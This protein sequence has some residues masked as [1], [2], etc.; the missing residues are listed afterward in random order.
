MPTATP[1]GE[2]R[3]RVT[4]LQELLTANGVGLALIRQPADLYYYTGTVADGFLAVPATGSPTLLARRPRG[5]L[6][7][8]EIPWEL[9]FYNDLGE[10]PNL[11]HDLSLPRDAPIG[12]E[13][14]VLPATLYL[15][16]HHKIFPGVPLRDISPLIRQQR[17][18]KSAFEIER[19]TGAAAI[20]DEAMASVSGLLCPGLTE[21]ELSAALE[22]RLRLLGHQ[23]LIRV[24]NFSLEIFF[25]HVLSGHAGLEAAYTDTP[26]GG[27]GF[28]PAFP[29]GASLKPLG[30]GEPVTV[31]LGS[32]VNGYVADMTR[33]FV[34]GDLPPA[35]WRAYDL[36]LELF[37]YFE[38]RARPGVK[39]GEL[40][41]GVCS[42]VDQAGLGDI[43]MG[44][45]QDQVSFLGHG[46]GLELDE[47][48]FI[49]DRFPFPL[50][51]NM[52]LAFE[53]KFF[54]PEVGLVGLEDTGRITAEG[55]EWL[56]RT[57]RQ[58]VKVP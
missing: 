11:L 23:G 37:H 56:T 9:A 7:G 21:L 54:V 15:R 6:A 1:V 12:L 29:Q 48:P 47:F 3:Q 19:I 52:V 10:V 49:T 45:N 51:V 46:V 34:L 57:S 41:Q 5:R 38:T 28:S 13:L 8:G 44:R 43:F 39:P 53:P 24:R 31:D 40:Y 26:S 20:L 2:T 18:V 35:A 22:Y 14:D 17:M 42:L 36:T 58:V 16:L 30:P 50:E 33:L 25:G 4:R 32:C 27:L 55:V